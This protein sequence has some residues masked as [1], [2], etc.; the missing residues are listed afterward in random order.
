RET[1]KLD[2]AL[3]YRFRVLSAELWAPQNWKHSLELLAPP[4]PQFPTAELAARRKL[5]EGLAYCYAQNFAQ[6]VNSLNEADQLTHATSPELLSR[7]AFYR[8]YLADIQGNKLATLHYRKSLQLAREAN[9]L[10]LQADIQ[11]NLGR[12]LLQQHQYDQAIDLFSQALERAQPAKARL[13]EERILGNL[14]VSHFELGDVD[15][16]ISYSLG[17][18]DIA[19][20]LGVSDDQRR[21]FM[22]LGR[23]YFAKANYSEAEKYY[24]RALSLAKDRLTIG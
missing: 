16:A 17:A 15:R 4:P 13:S 21:W 22:D 12:L 6:A 9:D 3:N 7:I 14:G 23:A 10:P 24:S 8:G 20:Q 19:S 2:P 18:E 11:M 5:A 1:A